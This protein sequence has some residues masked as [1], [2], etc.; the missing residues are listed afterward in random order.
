MLKPIYENIPWELKD[1]PQWVN[2]KSITRK[3]GD[4]PTKPPYQ[5]NGKLAESNNPLT[6][7]PFSVV[8]EAAPRYDGIGFVL[9]KDD[10]FVGLDF[11]H[12]R[13]PAFDSLDSEISGGLNMVL[14][15]VADY[16]RKLSSY[17]EVSPSGKGIRILLK[18]KLPVDGKKKGDFEA[19]Q[20]LHY[21]TMTGHVLDGFP[22]TIEPR[23]KEVDAFFQD[24]FGGTEKSPEQE[25]KALTDTSTGDWKERLERAF[26]S[27]NGAE[28]QRLYSGDHSAHPSQSEADLSLCSH[29]AFWFDGD[30]IAI[31]A[32][33]RES[34]LFRDKW[35]AK[36][37]GDGTTYGEATIK[38]AIAGCASF[39]GD[40]QSPENK[41]ENLPS[42][43]QPEV[44][45]ALSGDAF[46]GW[47]GDFVK[48]ACEHSE[49]DPAA[50][51][52]T[53]LGRFA[54]EVGAGPYVNI[55][56]ARHRARTNAAIVG[57]SSKS[58]KGTSKQSVDRL[59]NE[60]PSAARCTPGPLSSGEGLI[61]AVRDEVIEFNKKKQEYVTVDPGVIDKRLFV[62]DEEFAAAL[63]CTKREGNTLSA[64]IRGFFD[65]GNAEPL[66]KSFRIKATG[67]HVVIVTHITEMELISLLSQIQMSNGF[68]NRFL[69]ILSR[70][71]K[72]MALPSPM[73]DS[74][75][76]Q[77]RKIVIERI[78]S[79]R[80]L[81]AVGMSDDAKKLWI[82]S[83][84]GLT[85]AFEGVTGSVVNRI[86]AH[87]IRLALI[88][89]LCAGHSKIEVDDLKAAL[90]LVE[91]S[92][93]SAVRIFGSAVG[94]KKK[95]KIIDA[96]RSSDNHEMTISEISNNVF[97]RNINSDDLH[98]L[99]SELE[100]SK[101][102]VLEKS[103]TGGAPKT[104]VK[105][106]RPYETNEINEKSSSS[107]PLNS[108]NSLIRTS[109]TE[110][111]TFTEDDF[112]N[113]EP[114]L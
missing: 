19:Y 75:V 33:F 44:W 98:K 86:E 57:S 90:A 88:Y 63:N 106:Q 16:V 89:A 87:A 41:K 72:L 65:D 48:M 96:L 62:L 104:I 9:S 103:P 56:D 64:I 83:Y 112:L 82:E 34:V 20:A 111:I 6:W 10:P 14:P 53:L 49:A 51:L 42:L 70:R 74:E 17:T 93:R 95:I 7:S 47:I 58:R 91:Y 32:A 73:P 36:H 26:K 37:H 31:D 40:H 77:I 81:K 69:W 113:L 97:K 46:P 78:E 54:A 8:E 109:E 61:Y 66:T 80:D 99:L 85:M 3:E 55:G 102:I 28:I 105:F 52:V 11:D 60:I 24:V 76:D 108:L 92:R 27:K 100:S 18:G 15:V 114:P 71:Q 2:W 5:P 59:F 79:A 50:V 43:S 21:L 25:K 38:K 110:I 4:K 94:D 35:D 45:P 67:A 68:G 101:L 30:A 22:L 107:T 29:F 13:C 23:Q 1:F 39:Y 84:P 12:C